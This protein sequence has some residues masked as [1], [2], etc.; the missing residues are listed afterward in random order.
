M[1]EEHHGAFPGLDIGYFRAEDFDAFRFTRDHVDLRD[2]GS[3]PAELG[4]RRWRGQA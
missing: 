3:A 1:L 2:M 4:L